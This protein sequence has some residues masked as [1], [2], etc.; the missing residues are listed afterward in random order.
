MSNFFS[1]LKS[2]FT[3]IFNLVKGVN[4]KVT[5]VAG[6]YLP[7][8]TKV[9]DLMKSISGSVVTSTV[10]DAICKLLPNAPAK[11]VMTIYKWLSTELPAIADEIGVLSTDAK[12]K[13]GDALILAIFD[14]ISKLT[15]VNVKFN[16]YNTIARNLLQYLLKALDDGVLTTAEAA[17]GIAVFYESVKEARAATKG[18][19]ITAESAQKTENTVEN[20]VDT[21]VKVVSDVASDISKG[22]VA[23]A[24]IDAGKDI[25]EGV[26]DSKG[27]SAPIASPTE[28]AVNSNA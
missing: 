14:D 3:K 12:N 10:L 5:S 24:V 22:N 7:T 16:A 13:Q 4:D 9:V 18:E 17:T 19:T 6:D 2:F 11:V 28:S 20:V 15:G 25:V 27:V 23:E 26:A 8:V 21:T 1:N